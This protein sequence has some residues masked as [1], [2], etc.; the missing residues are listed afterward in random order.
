MQ[1][2]DLNAGQRSA[3]DEICRL[4]REK[5]EGVFSL[6]GAAGTG[7]TTMLKAIHTAFPTVPICAPTNKA[8]SVLRRKGIQIA[9]TVH[10]ACLKAVYSPSYRTK[11]QWV[12][13][14]CPDSEEQI[15]K[16]VGVKKE[17]LQA[18]FRELQR[19]EE[20][21]GEDSE[22][23]AASTL[24]RFGIKEEIAGWSPANDSAQIPFLVVDEG[25]MVG[26]NLLDSIRVV[27]HTILLVGDPNQ[28]PPVKDIDVLA[29]CTNI[30][31]LTQLMRH[32]DDSP[33]LAAAYHIL[34]T[35]DLENC[36]VV[37]K[38]RGSVLI[39]NMADRWKGPE[40]KHVPVICHSNRHRV[41]TIQRIRK[42]MGLPVD[43]VEPGEIIV[44][45]FND[46]NLGLY[47]NESVAV[48]RSS[49]K[50]SLGFYLPTIEG[51]ERFSN[52]DSYVEGLDGRLNFAKPLKKEFR[53]G[54]A[55]T[56][57]SAQGSQWKTCAI[58]IRAL[59]TLRHGKER[60][61][62]LYTAVTRAED[63]VVLIDMEK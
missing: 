6:T 28:L 13:N 30:A 35:G 24:L 63:K 36:P 41:D 37:K 21:Q 34:R 32:T 23:I 33:A 31:H 12:V 61:R 18:M 29:A 15:K 11:C 3:F 9:Q 50:G 47:N 40:E 42:Q 39:Q 38:Y 49:S 17:L 5:P 7:K 25:S 58:D 20:M 8:A 4:K 60:T 46:P 57:H 53:F 16:E 43:S 45:K 48:L 44:P 10:S 14:D 55:L 22:V 62:W 26:S 2:S 51:S 52:Y 19:S 54:Y 56:A 1:R 59:D 27:A